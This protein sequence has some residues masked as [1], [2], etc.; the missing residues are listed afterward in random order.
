MFRFNRPYLLLR[1]LKG[2]GRRIIDG[3][4]RIDGLPERGTVARPSRKSK[5]KG[6]NEKLHVQKLVLTSHPKGA[7]I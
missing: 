3:H 1:S 5:M 2:E 6:K 7:L 4:E